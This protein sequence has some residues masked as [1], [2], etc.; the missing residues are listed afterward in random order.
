M[1]KLTMFLRKNFHYFVAGFF[2]ISLTTFFY[3]DIIFSLSTHVLAGYQTGGYFT[4]LFWWWSYALKNNLPL[5]HSNFLMYPSGVPLFPHSPLNEITAI[6][7]QTFF[8]PAT[9]INVLSLASYIFTGLTAY[10]LFHKLTKSPA[11]SLCGSF[12]YAFSHYMLVQHYTGQVIEFTLYFNPL[13]ALAWTRYLEQPGGRRALWL[14]LTF[15]GTF[16]SGPYVGFCFGLVFSLGVFLFDLFFGGRKLLKFQSGM[17]A[18]LGL[19][20]P[21][22]IIIPIYWPL[23]RHVGEWKGGAYLWPN[24]FLSFI[25]MP[26]WHR[27]SWIQSIRPFKNI[28]FYPEQS[29]SFLG[30]GAFLCLGYATWKKWW[31]EKHFKF[32]FFI[33]GFSAILSL[34]PSMHLTP[35][36]DLFIPLPYWVFT[37]IPLASSFRSIFRILMT[38]TLASS[39]LVSLTLAKWMA[40]FS[41][42][43]QALVTILF[44]GFTILEFDMPVIG[45]WAISLPP[46]RSYQVIKDDNEKFAIMELPMTYDQSGTLHVLGQYY[47]VFQPYHQKPMVLGYPSRYLSSNLR[48]TDTTPFVYELTHPAVLRKLDENP[49]LKIRSNW[50]IQNGKTVLKKAGIKY[51]IFHSRVPIFDSD[52]K[53]RLKDWLLKSLGSP[54]LED[55]KG[56][57]LF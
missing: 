40:R 42:T 57:L 21:F 50:L 27:S 26:F 7:L 47:M 9:T 33:F 18:F 32:W 4:W 43:T 19:L 29:M 6:L 24:S 49:S 30:F 45:K 8:S 51:V 11:A 44:I 25:D 13:F 15:L 2:F 48:F 36:R 37:K 23:I 54:I 55:E 1:N 35:T 10:V 39:C 41:K 22:F 3:K 31:A 53:K 16:L 52:L 28:D 17:P 14:G 20:I 5:F 46:S 12:A 34:G 38:V 56:N